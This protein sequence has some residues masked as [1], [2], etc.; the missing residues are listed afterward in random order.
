MLAATAGGWEGLTTL[1]TPGG[2]NHFF[3]ELL[4][5]V[6]GVVSFGSIYDLVIFNRTEVIY[7]LQYADTAALGAGGRQHGLPI[8]FIHKVTGLHISNIGNINTTIC[9]NTYNSE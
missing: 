5:Y 6:F 7:T 2:F 9:E 3:F 8:E 4:I 1:F